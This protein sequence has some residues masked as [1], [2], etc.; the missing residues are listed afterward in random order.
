MPRVPPGI[1]SLQIH[2]EGDTA[3]LRAPALPAAPGLQAK[4]DAVS[5]ARTAPG[6]LC[7]Q[8]NG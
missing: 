8:E 6:W 7:L 1:F 2:N 5:S 4:H 3:L